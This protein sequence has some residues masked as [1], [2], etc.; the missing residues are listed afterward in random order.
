MR[1]STSLKPAID[2]QGE[3]DVTSLYVGVNE[4]RG[5]GSDHGTSRL[6]A[7]LKATA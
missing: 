4:P 2:A 7:R 6:R 5:V 1:P 3:F